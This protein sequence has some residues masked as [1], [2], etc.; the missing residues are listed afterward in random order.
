MQVRKEVE[1]NH[2]DD[3]AEKE[4]QNQVGNEKKQNIIELTDE[5]EQ[6]KVQTELSTDDTMQKE[7]GGSE[8]LSTSNFISSEAEEIKTG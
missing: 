5:S 7:E 3:E 8:S 1:K 2:N 4:D 6:L